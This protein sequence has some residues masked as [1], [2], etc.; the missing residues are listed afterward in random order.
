[1]RKYLLL[2]LSFVFHFSALSADNYTFCYWV[3][4]NHTA[5]QT[6]T[7]ATNKF[8]TTMDVASLPE[9]MHTLFVRARKNTGTWTSPKASHFYKVLDPTTVKT[10]YWFNDNED[11]RFEVAKTN[12][13]T[14]TIDV[15][16]LSDGTHTLH[17]RMEGEGTASSATVSS[18][19]LK[20]STHFNAYYW[21]DS[22]T[23]RHEFANAGGSSMLIDVS[24]LKEGLHCFNA[25][26]LNDSGTPT[27]VVSRT[28][29]KIAQPTAN[30]STTL[31]FW[32]DGKQHSEQKVAYGNEIVD[33]ELDVA[34][35]ST[36]MHYLKVQAMT[37]SGATSNIASAYFMRMPYQ[38][39]DGV[40]ACR[41]WV[42]D[43]NADLPFTA[44]E[45]PTLPYTLIGDLD[46]TPQPLR[47]ANFHFEVNN[48]M[49]MLYAVNDLHV[50]FMA[51]D[52]HLIK[53][54]NQYV[55]S[56]A[57]DT[58]T[59]EKWTEIKNDT[60]IKANTPTGETIYWYAMNLEAGDTVCLK[61]NY[62]STLQVFSH[63]A[64]K[65]FESQ[66]D[67]SLI[68]RQF[69][70]EKDE[71]YYLALHTVNTTKA[72][73]TLT[74]DL[75][76]LIHYYT[77][78]TSTNGHGT[79][80][81]G[82]IYAEGTLI[83]LT[84][85]PTE[86]HQFAR[87]NDGNTDNPR[88]LVLTQDTALTAYFEYVVLDTEYKTICYGDSCV[89]NGKTYT[90]SGIYI[91]TLQTGI[92]TL[93]L[94][95]LPEVPITNEEAVICSSEVYEWQ[96]Q[97]YTKSGTYSVTLSDINGCDSILT[98]N[99]T[100]NYGDTIEFTETACDSYEWHGEVYTKSGDYTY[101]TQTTLGCDS[102]EVLHLTIHN[103]EVGET[104]YVTVCYG[105]TYTWNGRTYS[106]AGEYTLTLSNTN[107][108]DSVATLQLTIMPEAVTTTETVVIGSNELPY[109]WRGQSINATGR[110]TDVEQYTTIAC[111]SAIHVLDL[112]VL[113]TG[114]YDEQSV[115]ICD[116]EAPY[117]WYGES[118][119]ATG[120]YTYTE[121]YVGTDIDSIQH[122]LNLTVNSTV[123]TEEHITACDSYTWNGETYTQSGEY[124]YTT[125]TANGCDSIVTLHLT[126]N[127]TQYAEESVTACDTYI[128][129]GET[130]S[131]S[132][133]YTYTTTAAN[134]CDSIVTLHLTINQTKF[135]EETV[136]ACDSYAW[137]SETYT[138][139]GEYTYTTTAA[140]GCDSIVTL[141]LTINQTQY[142]EE[143][144]TACD[145]YTWNGETYTQSGEYVY[146]TTAANGCDSIV[147]L[148]LT[149]NNSEIGATEYATICYGE[150]YTWNGQTYSAEGEYSITL[151]N[152][153]GCDS[154]AT[155]QLTIMP[156]ATAT[157]ETVVIGSDELPYTWR[158]NTY[159]T[160]GQYTVVEQ[161]TTVACD[162]AIHVLDL[163]VL[164]TGN[165][166]EQ[167]ITICETEAPYTWYGESYSATGKYTYTEKYVSTDI[168]SI[169]HILN[170][171]VNPTVYTEEHIT[172]CDSYT[173]NG[174]T[175][176]QSGD[177]VYTTTA[178]NG[179]D[180][181]V[182]LHLTLN[183]SEHVEFS[184][185]A[186]DSYEWHGMTY[187]ISGDYTYNTTTE[188]GCERIEVLHLTILPD[189]TTESEE[190]SLCPSELP[191][192]W[193]GQWLT[194]AGSY[195]ASEQYAG[196][197]CDSVIHELI[198]NV[199]VQ[200]LPATVTQPIVRT[201]DAID[202]TIPTA[203][204]QAHIAAETWYAPNAEVAWY[205]MDNSDWT[206]LTTDPV[207]AGTKQVT[208]K[209]A[210]ETDCGNVE[211]ENM[212]IAIEPTG[213]ENT[214]SPSPIPNCQKILHEDHI[215][216]LRDGKIYTIMG[217]EL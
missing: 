82:G 57:A 103:S 98:L 86:G 176:T 108:C 163:T 74:V 211:S 168:D 209:Y 144:V 115:T 61:T 52:G 210:V 4:D 201:G 154:V 191:Y 9:G 26:L 114:N 56:I 45:N 173:W 92:A 202:V 167:S 145:A 185:T 213:V 16:H 22:E 32:I 77:V 141:H 68:F 121:Q 19:F 84:A 160:T 175:Y 178:A 190:L 130:Y 153:L 212:V 124:V 91:D 203:E 83:T 54:V 192:E 196:M 127:Y 65:V 40:V 73:V 71:M 194:E 47:C 109:T 27:A 48:D 150:T 72:Q 206:A 151:S 99:L 6:I 187:T 97:T 133:D 181:I 134:D 129:N 143:H 164:S 76:K 36:G 149:I 23:E 197:E 51:A 80:T 106:T 63:S 53:S 165:Y 8:S 66:A 3:D 118:Y 166:D 104:E 10:Y 112:T 110:Y 5:A 126:I 214:Q 69:I 34:D 116:T 87:W 75:N 198:V 132:G 152:T 21:F 208:L 159:S 25:M 49:P 31:T 46:V 128:W 64:D 37:N 62:S 188:Q 140:N 13:E 88:T 58:L 205:I 186:C 81:E 39:S 11:N 24:H 55:E 177:Y 41:Y 199:Y 139:S 15:S 135:A 60:V 12:G 85:T 122:I 18:Q 101:L 94:T 105:E 174:G 172:A 59:A 147:T 215:Y 183:Q 70:A 7:Q 38:N 137:N 111:D 182:T 179:C 217:Q 146:T 43:N 113:T 184:M 123:Y 120:K 158:G 157:T 148:H 216:I 193:Y 44:V 171:T 156:E 180:S 20:I 33:F 95:I 119:S 131:K 17:V 169:Q 161:Y 30:D 42:N 50:Q 204:I 170:L 138:A 35:L 79:V 195:T 207:A 155:L 200:T 1:M 78:A 162:S 28:F 90:T 125:T 89:W 29:L 107:G 100:V 102:L 117:L 142:A 96:G 93:D 2:I 136:V 14:F 67:S 189:A